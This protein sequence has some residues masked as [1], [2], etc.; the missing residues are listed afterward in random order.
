MMRDPGRL[1]HFYKELEKMHK[2]E[3]PDWRFGQF[4]SNL[5]SWFMSEKKIDPFFVEE[6]QMLGYLKEFFKPYDG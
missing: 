6:D 5:F 3:I 4:M 2:E 1:S